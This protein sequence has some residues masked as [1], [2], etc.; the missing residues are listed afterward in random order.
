M[1]FHL[2]RE[3]RQRRREAFGVLTLVWS[4]FA[5]D[6]LDTYTN[7]SEIDLGRKPATEVKVR[8]TL[9]LSSL[10]LAFLFRQRH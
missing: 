5:S 6:R 7:E 9:S 10:S 3:R 1:T 8:S 2:Q 4:Q